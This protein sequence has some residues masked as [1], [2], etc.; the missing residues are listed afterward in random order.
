MSC[1]P[2]FFVDSPATLVFF[3]G[4]RSLIDNCGIGDVGPSS[5]E[6]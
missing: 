6:V 4:D 5:V 3:A 1:R 2:F